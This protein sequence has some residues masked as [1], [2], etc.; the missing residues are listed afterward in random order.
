MD[1]QGESQW[2]IDEYYYN[3]LLNLWTQFINMWYSSSFQRKDELEEGR[4]YKF[5]LQHK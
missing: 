2:S 5:Y 3:F 1:I 4:T